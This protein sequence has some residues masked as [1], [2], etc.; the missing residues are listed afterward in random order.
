MSH[1]IF[2]H[3]ASERGKKSKDN[4]LYLFGRTEEGKSVAVNIIDFK[5]HVTIQIE[6]NTNKEKFEEDMQSN[7]LELLATKKIK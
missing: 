1:L 2:Q 7:F 5:P 6:R 3:I 4:V